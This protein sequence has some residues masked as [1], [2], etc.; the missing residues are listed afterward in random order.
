MKSGV[1]DEMVGRVVE[2]LRA[3][4]DETRV[5][6]L[7]RLK[8]GECNVT[9]LAGELGVAQ[10]SVSKHLGILRQAGILSLRREGTQSFYAVRDQSIFEL[11]KLVCDGIVRHAEAEHRALG[12]GA[13]KSRK[14]VGR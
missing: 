14:R 9:T 4:A 1:S 5:R 12:L 6:L 8:G 11:C 10:A 7:L 13:A 3:I 2:R